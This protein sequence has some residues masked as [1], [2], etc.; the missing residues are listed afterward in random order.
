MENFFGEKLDSAKDL[1]GKLEAAIQ[2]GDLAPGTRM[3]TERR[4]A[5]L[6]GL[7]RAT[8]RSA[9]E[10]LRQRGLITRRVGQG[11]FVSAS[12]ATDRQ[13]IVSGDGSA[14]PTPRQFMEFRLLTEP[15]L[16][17]HIVLCAS[18][19]FLAEFADFVYESR[20]ARDWRETEHADAEFHRRLFCA[21][22]NPMLTGVA[23]LMAAARQSPAWLM[24]KQR[25]FDWPRWKRY[26]S[27]HEAIVT[28]LQARD[29][30]RAQKLLQNHLTGVNQRFEV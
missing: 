19:E 2:S 15:G 11:T 23:R 16:A 6:V 27:E 18:D 21:T 14:H 8:V 13:M 4:M 30:V 9:L 22:D 7:S 24:L 29:S 20:K 5:E 3:L 26:Q 1:L 17:E 28:A 25:R 10:M 12:L